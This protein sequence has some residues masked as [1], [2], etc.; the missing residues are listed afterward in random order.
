V[1]GL[2]FDHGAEVKNLGHHFAGFDLRSQSV[3]NPGGRI[4]DK[5]KGGRL[6]LLPS[7][8]TRE[9]IMFKIIG[10]AVVYGFALFGL[11]RYLDALHSDG[12]AS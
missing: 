12:E 5:G 11:A 3:R 1:Q 7:T 9:A 8:R 6:S 10:A 2:G 4:V